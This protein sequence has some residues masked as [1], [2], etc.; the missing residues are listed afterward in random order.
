MLF[1]SQYATM[2][3]KFH[4]AHHH[5]DYSSFTQEL[6]YRSTYQKKEG[7][8]NYGMKVVKIPEEWSL[9]VHKDCNSYIL[10]HLDETEK[11]L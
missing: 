9:D 6:E 10:Q 7:I 8:N 2:V 5:V 1:R 11:V 3:Y 4:R